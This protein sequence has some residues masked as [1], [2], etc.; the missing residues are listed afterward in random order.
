MEICNEIQS[1]QRELSVQEHIIE[2]VQSMLQDDDIIK[3][4][5]LGCMR[6]AMM[7]NIIEK[8]ETIITKLWC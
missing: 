6:T 8:L 2:N 7:K 4:V 5:A 3:D 1:L